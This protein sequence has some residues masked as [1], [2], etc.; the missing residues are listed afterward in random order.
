[1]LDRFYEI[2]STALN[3]CVPLK[4]SKVLNFSKWIHKRA[5]KLKKNLVSNFLKK[6]LYSRLETYQK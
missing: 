2:V 6:D 4:L 5:K 1:M 3:N